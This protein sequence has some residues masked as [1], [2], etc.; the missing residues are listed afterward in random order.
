MFR[1]KGLLPLIISAILFISNAS[2]GQQE[3]GF[4]MPPGVKSVQLPFEEFSNLIVV[5]VTINGFVTL[6]FVLDTGAESIILTEKIFGDILSLNYV[7]TITIDGPGIRDSIKA[8]V[9]TNVYISLPGG[10]K[11]KGMNML[12]LEEDYIELNKNLGEEIYGIIGYDLFS[13]FVVEVDYSEKLITI[14]DP[15]FFRPRK[16]FIKVPM[17]VRTT[18]PFVDC[19]IHHREKVDTLS[20]MVD[21]GASHALLL[22]HEV[23]DHIITVD[24]KI[25]ASL[26]QGIGGQIP[27]Y[28]S[29]LDE[30]SIGSM[31]FENILISVPKP[32]VYIDALK[33]GSRHGTLGGDLLSRL[34]IILDYPHQAL[35]IEREPTR[36]EKFE[37]DMS[38][39]RLLA[40]GREL[41]SIIVADV[42][43][44]SP[45]QKS[46]IRPGDYILRINGMTPY[47]STISQMVTLLRKKDNT[48]VRAR[49]YRDGK[50]LKKQFRLNRIV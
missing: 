43:P 46:D 33:R 1:K 29:R 18:K 45:A 23:T 47:S 20:L 42:R 35:Y 28:L 41:D 38:G 39:I 17:K 31:A 32:G 19:I 12:V 49:I 9:A 5:P 27:G 25:E 37:Y 10:I 13:R 16:T 48:L 22:D 34:H 21:S 44:D 30:Y 4:L 24:R 15:K 26:G 40:A 50:K 3:I 7:R 36:H 14:H 11:A 2:Y 6:K 8:H